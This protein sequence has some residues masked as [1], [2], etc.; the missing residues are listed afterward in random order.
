M[1]RLRYLIYTFLLLFPANVFASS[2][3]LGCP[4]EVKASEEFICTIYGPEHASELMINVS[5]PDN[6][7]FK[8]YI[9]GKNYTLNKINNTLNFVGSGD[10]ERIAAIIKIVAPNITA[11]T[12]YTFNLNNIKYKFYSTDTDY[13]TDNDIL[14]TI[15]VKGK[16]IIPS[17]TTTMKTENFV[18][19]LDANGSNDLTQTLSCT[20]KN[21]SCDIYLS[22]STPTREGF[23]FNGWGLNKDCTEG[24]I[25]TF[26]LNADTILYACWQGNVTTKV[27]YLENLE[28]VGYNLE[29]SKFK[30]DYN[31][32]VEENVEDLVIN[33][34]PLNKNA[35]V[36]INKPDKLD[37]GENNITISITDNDKNSIYTIKVIKG[38]N[39]PIIKNKLISLFVENYNLDFNPNTLNYTLEIKST[40]SKLSLSAVT[41][42]ANNTYE[43][44]NNDNLKNGSVITISVING[45]GETTDYTISIQKMSIFA[46]FK[47]YFIIAGI[48]IFMFTVYFIVRHIK[49]KN[50]ELE[51]KN[52]KSKKSKDSKGK[53]IVVSTAPSESSKIETL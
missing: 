33:A 1:K 24:S 44:K 11:D 26:T 52:K 20:P 9:N 32:S 15:L 49:R 8:S 38:S 13:T 50:G 30:F 25:D 2:I 29:F 47:I 39:L 31:L 10:H 4:A 16:K 48:V 36:V 3:S 21:G 6:F 14:K 41:E 28:V 12:N 23:T 5:L 43:I 37:M 51:P 7:V 17:T 40:I 42:D 53:P 34:I 22:N 18:A 46:E 35:K 45:S 27:A 19:T